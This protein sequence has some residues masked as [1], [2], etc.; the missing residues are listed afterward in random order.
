MRNLE[1]LNKII[2][3]FTPIKLYIDVF[4]LVYFVIADL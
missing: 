3:L 4:I 2:I 1:T